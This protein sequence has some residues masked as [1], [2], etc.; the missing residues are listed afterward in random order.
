MGLRAEMRRAT[1]EKKAKTAVYQFS[2]EQLDAKIQ[3]LVGNR[4]E[5]IKEAATQ[6]AINVAL[7]LM[8]LLPMNV[9]S[10]H[11]WPK[12]YQKKLPEFENLLLEDYNRWQNDE[13]DMDILREKLY[14][15]CGIRLELSEKGE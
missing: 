12:T 5:E 4:L 2:Q 13:L 6:D 14:E 9:L 1:R 8:M 10:E 11:F 15:T 7:E 3:E